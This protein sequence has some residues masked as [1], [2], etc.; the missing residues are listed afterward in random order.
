MRNKSS[1]RSR[2]ID[3]SSRFVS[4]GITIMT[5]SPFVRRTISSDT[6]RRHPN[7]SVVCRLLIPEMYMR[8]ELTSDAADGDQLPSDPSATTTELSTRGTDGTLYSLGAM[9]GVVWRSLVLSP[10]RGVA[11][12]LVISDGGLVA[13][14]PFLLLIGDA[15]AGVTGGMSNATGTTLY[16]EDGCR[17]VFRQESLM[18][19]P[20]RTSAPL[21]TACWMSWC[22][23]VGC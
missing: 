5:K 20:I 9:Q 18:L 6:S 14:F 2:L 22:L 3:F 4:A 23:V 11:D 1:F 19:C 12:A 16:F 10:R 17:N 8:V 13:V 7:D 21:R 15:G